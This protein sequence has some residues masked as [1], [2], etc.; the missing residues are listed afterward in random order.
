MT[1]DQLISFLSMIF[2]LF[3]DSACS[4]T[5]SVIFFSVAS[6]SSS[7]YSRLLSSIPCGPA[8]LSP[9]YLYPQPSLLF[10]NGAL[11]FSSSF[12]FFLFRFQYQRPRSWAHGGGA[13]EARS[14]LSRNKE[15][16]LRTTY[17]LRGCPETFPIAFNEK[18]QYIILTLNH[19]A[20]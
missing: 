14:Y 16:K 7:V 5:F 17:E 10:P 4:T 8:F 1:G 12:C 6:I 19:I 11:H 15:G 2:N 20:L 18:R 3:L 13:T 9:R